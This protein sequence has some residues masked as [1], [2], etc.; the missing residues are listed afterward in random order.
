MLLLAHLSEFQHGSLWLGF[1]AVSVV[2]PV[3]YTVIVLA[4]DLNVRE[5]LQW[6]WNMGI[7]ATRVILYNGLTT[8]ALLIFSYRCGGRDNLGSFVSKRRSRPD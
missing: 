8:A 5:R 2:V 1:I 6:E 4:I 7:T 3:V